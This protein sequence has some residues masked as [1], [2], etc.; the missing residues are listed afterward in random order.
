MRA[1]F[2]FADGVIWQRDDVFGAV[3]AEGDAPGSAGYNGAIESDDAAGGSTG[4][5]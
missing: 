3:G 1:C 4:F 5:L 2:F